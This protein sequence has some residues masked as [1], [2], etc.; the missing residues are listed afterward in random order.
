MLHLDTG[1]RLFFLVTFT[2]EHDVIY[3]N[4]SNQKETPSK[5]TPVSCSFL[6]VFF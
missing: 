5:K 4:S 1:W 2:G 6:G 3:I